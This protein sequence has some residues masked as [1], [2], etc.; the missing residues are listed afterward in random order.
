MKT[1]NGSTSSAST[2]TLRAI[3]GRRSPAAAKRIAPPP[4]PKPAGGVAPATPGLASSLARTL[5]RSLL[6][7]KP[8]TSPKRPG[9]RATGLS[10]A[11]M[12]QLHRAPPSSDGFVPGVTPCSLCA[13]PILR[14][15]DALSP[16]LASG[17]V[18]I[19]RYCYE[20]LAPRR[21]GAGNGT[22]RRG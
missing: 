17:I 16:G 10:K 7:P 5:P 20:R 1:K 6:L 13:Q 3:A 22:S 4:P 15:A 14:A 11:L 21:K 18:V 12:L 9:P 8:P 2:S 19:H